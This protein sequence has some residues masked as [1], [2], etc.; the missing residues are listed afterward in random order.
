MSEELDVLLLVADRLEAVGV[1]YMLSGS[2]AMNVYAEP[3]MTRDID[4]VVDIGARHVDAIGA[5]FA[6]DFYCDRDMIRQAVAAEGTFNVIHTATVIKVDFIVRKSTPYRRLEFERRRSVTVDGH[7]IWVVAPEDL[8]L[9]K[10][11]WAKPS[12]SELQLGDVRNLIACTPD[13]D[14]AYVEHWARDLTVTDLLA[15]VRS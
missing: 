4:L 13:L 7:P 5:S 8:V 9:S 6:S 14:W 1:A 15:E 3:R 12:R 2:T 10:L 11:A